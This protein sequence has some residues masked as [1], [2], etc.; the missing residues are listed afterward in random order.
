MQVH[1]LKNENNTAP[2]SSMWT[3]LPKHT[4]NDMIASRLLNHIR[5]QLRR[6]GRPALVF[7]ILPGVREERDNR[8]DSLRARNFACMYHDAQLHKG[9]VDLSTTRID[10]VDIVF[11]NRL[12][13]ADTSLADST[14]GYFCFANGQA[15]A[16][17]RNE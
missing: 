11:S 13:D 12:D 5:Y 17:R 14:L 1:C 9:R 15:E 6:D 4:Y 8:R 16:T 7:L 2:L 3:A 10:D